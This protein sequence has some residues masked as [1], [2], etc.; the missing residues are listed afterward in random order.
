MC[1]SQII[2]ILNVFLYALVKDWIMK[3]KGFKY[4]QFMPLSGVKAFTLFLVF[5]F[6]ILIFF[7]YV[8]WVSLRATVETN[9]SSVVRSKRVTNSQ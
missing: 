1:P 2:R 9:S 7:F 8:N 5:W 6:S 4:L 3:V